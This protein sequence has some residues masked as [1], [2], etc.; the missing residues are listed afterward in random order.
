[1]LREDNS[2][3]DYLRP[4]HRTH[5]LETCCMIINHGFLSG[6]NGTTFSPLTT[7]SPWTAFQRLWPTYNRTI[8]FKNL[9]YLENSQRFLMTFGTQFGHTV[10]NSIMSNKHPDESK[11]PKASRPNRMDSNW[12]HN[13]IIHAQSLTVFEII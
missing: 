1:M 3:V 6:V 5:T 7:F 13:F 4:S 8:K 10:H 9:N 2:W 12:V 11:L